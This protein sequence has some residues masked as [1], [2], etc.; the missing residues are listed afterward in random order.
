MG[1][2]VKEFQA[3][4]TESGRL[5]PANDLLLMNEVQATIHAMAEGHP[6]T[7]EVETSGQLGQ[8]KKIPEKRNSVVFGY[9]APVGEADLGVGFRATQ[10]GSIGRT[11]L[12]GW[13]DKALIEAR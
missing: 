12:G 7:G 8:R 2:W 3:W 13:F 5:Q 1:S 11:W 4:R 10:A 6:A 9:G